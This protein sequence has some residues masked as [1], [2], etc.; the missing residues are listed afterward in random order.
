MYAELIENLTP[1]DRKELA[2]H[3][4]PQS[5]VSEWK[6]GFRLPTRSQ[7]LALA[8]VKKVDLATLERELT[9]LEV[10]KDAEKNEGFAALMK[11]VK[12]AWHFI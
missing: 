2:A 5:R 7:A 9:V 8:T 12:G 4:V 11:S 3:G 10:T 6:T 1:S